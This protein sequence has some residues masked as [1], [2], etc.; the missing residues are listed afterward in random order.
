MLGLETSRHPFLQV[1]A[2]EPRSLEPWNLR[3][4]I[5]EPSSLGLGLGTMETRSS[6]LMKREIETKELG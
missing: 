2:L 4:L 1:S 3:V 6:S 5:L